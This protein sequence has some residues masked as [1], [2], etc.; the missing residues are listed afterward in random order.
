MGARW[1]DLLR[2]G[3][4]TLD[5]DTFHA[6]AAQPGAGDLGVVGERNFEHLAVFGA[7]P[8]NLTRRQV[9]VAV[10]LVAHGSEATTPQHAVSHGLIPPN[11]SELKLY[12]LTTLWR[13]RA[14]PGPTSSPER[15]A[16][17]Y[18]TGITAGTAL[19]CGRGPSHTTPAVPLVWSRCR[20]EPRRPAAAVLPAILSATRLRTTGVGQRGQDAA[21]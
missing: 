14:F 16:A 2:L 13:T 12:G 6:V 15:D 5:Q 4:I 10:S 7:I 3:L 18:D 20:R 21:G 17:F 9:V 19:Q 1:L 11:S 8:R